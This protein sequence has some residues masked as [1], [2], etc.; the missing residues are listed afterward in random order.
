MRVQS[1]SGVPINGV[2]SLKVKLLPVKEA[3]V[4]ARPSTHPNMQWQKGDAI[5]CN[6]I[7]CRFESCLH[8]QHPGEGKEVNPSGLEPEEAGSTPA[9]LT[10]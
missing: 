8:V 1:S 9:A 5:G 7:P 4:G 3:D 10:K 6:P 2:C